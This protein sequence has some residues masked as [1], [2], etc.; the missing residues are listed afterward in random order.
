MSIL[1]EEQKTELGSMWGKRP[2]RIKMVEIEADIDLVR[3]SRRILAGPGLRLRRVGS[4]ELPLRFEVAP[5]QGGSGRIAKDLA[6]G[7]RP[8]RSLETAAAWATAAI[9]GDQQHPEL[10]IAP[11]ARAAAARQEPEWP[12]LREA[13]AP[14]RPA[15]RIG[16]E[17]VVEHVRQRRRPAEPDP[18]STPPRDEDAVP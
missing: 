9:H 6:R 18:A 1:I 12:K 5:A 10:V 2:V 13:P 16:R 7:D 17:D 14:I 4:S 3:E 11:P 8:Q 15:V